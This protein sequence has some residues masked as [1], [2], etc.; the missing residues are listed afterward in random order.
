MIVGVTTYDPTLYISEALAKRLARASENRLGGR[1][2][3][4]DAA[5]E[6]V[7]RALLS[8]LAGLCAAE[9]MKARR[10]AS[11]FP[12]KFIVINGGQFVEHVELRLAASLGI[13]PGKHTRR[14]LKTLATEVAA[15]I[16]ERGE[17]AVGRSARLVPGLSGNWQLVVDELPLDLWATSPAKRDHLEER[18]VSNVTPISTHDLFSTGRRR[19]FG[20][21][22]AW[23]TPPKLPDVYRCAAG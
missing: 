9:R 8:T 3:N 20:E 7:T 19:R 23:D 16:S 17:L 4:V 14:L 21:L 11:G 12:R 5:R 22:N 15:E 6:S 13:A 10:S 18:G 2:F 1:E